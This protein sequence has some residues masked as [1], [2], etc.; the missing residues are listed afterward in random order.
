MIDPSGDDN[1]LEERVTGV[2]PGYFIN[3]ISV[4]K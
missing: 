4:L 2:E 3:N 1:D